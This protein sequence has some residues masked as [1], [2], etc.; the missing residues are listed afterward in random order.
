MTAR[1]TAPRRSTVALVAVAAATLAACGAEPEANDDDDGNTL[2][3]RRLVRIE[4]TSSLVAARD[5][6]MTFL[7][8]H[9]GGAFLYVAG[10]IQDSARPILSIERAPVLDDGGLGAFAAVDSLETWTAGGPVVVDGQ[11][12]Y[13]FSGLRREGS[14][15]VHTPAVDI[16]DVSEDGTFTW[17]AGPDMANA[18][19]HGG[20][21]HVGDRIYVVGGLVGTFVNHASVESAR[22]EADGS[23]SAW[24]EETDLPLPLSHHGLS[25]V[26]ERLVVTGGISGDSRVEPSLDTVWIAELDGEGRVGAW[27]EQ[28]TRLREGSSV[29]AT[30]VFDDALYTV[31]G[32]A[33]AEH[34]LGGVT[35]SDVTDGIGAFAPSDAAFE[36]R[37]HAHQAPVFGARFY[38]TGG[39]TFAP[40]G[41]HQSHAEVFVGV[42]E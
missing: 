20:A 28:D 4:E 5:H 32:L 9:A 16:A 8:E 14:A 42:F 17:R 26:G 35:V 13:F 15:A 33:G 1:H 21:A 12:V 19:G 22:I 23:L 29:H 30:V 7:M 25:V 31:G 6:H 27:V 24:R 40:G 41:A 18:R 10:G 37:A 38:L 34:G 3:A 36:G 39:V 2:T 11:R